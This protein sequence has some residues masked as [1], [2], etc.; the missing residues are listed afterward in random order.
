MFAWLPSS[1]RVLSAKTSSL[2]VTVRGVEVHR[3]Q[4]RLAVCWL[5]I[6]QPVFSSYSTHG[7]EVS[8]V[9]VCK[10]HAHSVSYTDCDDNVAVRG[11]QA[12]PLVHTFCP[13]K[14]FLRAGRHKEGFWALY[15]S[16][17]AASCCPEDGG[18]SP[19]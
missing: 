12:Q 2:H 19:R 16:G 11:P 15:R 10:A 8:S 3:R 13:N 14:A 9:C 1:G 7:A 17:D 6:G 4:D 18:S 5:S